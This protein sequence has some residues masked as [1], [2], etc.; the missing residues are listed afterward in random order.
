MGGKDSTNL[1]EGL[2]HY[3]A[4]IAIESYVTIPLISASSCSVHQFAFLWGTWLEFR[5]QKAEIL[6]SSRCSQFVALVFMLWL[7]FLKT[8]CKDHLL[9][10][11]A[12]TQP[13]PSVAKWKKRTFKKNSICKP[14]GSFVSWKVVPHCI[15]SGSKKQPTPISVLVMPSAEATQLFPVCCFLS[16][17]NG[18]L[19]L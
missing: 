6:L 10:S 18:I 8:S 7:N 1:W 17:V 15:L 2:N 16:K 12:C 11:D 4:A 14:Y 3:A 13:V 5:L 19:G 9:E